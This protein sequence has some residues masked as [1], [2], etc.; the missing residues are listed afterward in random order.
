MPS[1][2]R[3]SH[4]NKFTIVGK[5]TT[6]FLKST[7]LPRNTCLVGRWVRVHPRT[8]TR[9]SRGHTLTLM[10]YKRQGLQ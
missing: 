7:L 6:D 8:C 9:Y 3:K 4:R 10:R 2:M 5:L 1:D